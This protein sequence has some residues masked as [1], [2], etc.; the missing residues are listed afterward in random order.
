VDVQVRRSTAPEHDMSE[1]EPI[2]S[3]K[4]GLAASKAGLR[5]GIAMFLVILIG[6]VVAVGLIHKAPAKQVGPTTG[7]TASTKTT[8]IT[9]K[10]KTES[11]AALSHELSTFYELETRG[12]NSTFSATYSERGVASLLGGDQATVTTW[13]GPKSRP[14]AFEEVTADGAAEE[15]MANGLTSCVRFQ[16]RSWACYTI[17]TPMMGAEAD[18]QLNNPPLFIE[19]Q[20]GNFLGVLQSANTL[21]LTAESAKVVEGRVGGRDASCLSASVKQT[22][23]TQPAGNRVERLQVCL[24]SS[25]VPLSFSQ[26][27]VDIGET[28]EITLKTLSSTVVPKDFVPASPPS[29]SG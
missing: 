16:G 15:I 1:S 18:F 17:A 4:S 22:E 2:P 28:T 29:L 9:I 19:L 26:S 12:L 5:V 27:G 21:G 8:P 20:V 11:V 13:N 3:D 10:T 23:A 7:M 25:G 14:Q 24:T 6:V